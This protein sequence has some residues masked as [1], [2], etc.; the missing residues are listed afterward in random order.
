MI[1]QER[2]VTQMGEDFQRMAKKTEREMIKIREQMDKLQ[3]SQGKDVR[4]I[5]T[6]K[7]VIINCNLTS[8][9]T[10]LYS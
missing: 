7:R 2:E 10:V 6:L 9:H 1:K 8:Y 5:T 4:R 3:T